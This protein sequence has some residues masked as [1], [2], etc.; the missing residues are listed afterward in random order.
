L[1]SILVNTFDVP[2]EWAAGYAI[3]RVFD[4]TQVLNALAAFWFGFIVPLDALTDGLLEVIPG[5]VAEPA[6]DLALV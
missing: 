2:G 6:H 3:V 1:R 5:L 4:N